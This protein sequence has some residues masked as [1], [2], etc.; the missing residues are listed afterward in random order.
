MGRGDNQHGRPHG[1]PLK[2][3][4]E[5]TGVRDGSIDALGGQNGAKMV[6]SSSR[7]VY[8]CQ[9]GQDEADAEVDHGDDDRSVNQRYR[10]TLQQ[11][12]LSAGGESGPATADVEAQSYH[13]QWPDV[14]PDIGVGQRRYPKI[15][16]L[17]AIEIASLSS[18]LYMFDL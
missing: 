1:H 12:D 13:R 6:L 7:R 10:P 4:D 9:L 15:M 8:T 5:A 18:S 14:F 11:S 16:G 2:D 3:G 17:R